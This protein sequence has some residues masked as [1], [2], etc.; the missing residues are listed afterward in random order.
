GTEPWRHMT[1]SIAKWVC[2]E[3]GFIACLG[4]VVVALSAAGSISGERDRD[5][6][7]GLR[8]TPLDHVQILTA[9]RLG[10]IFSAR[11]LVLW[12]CLIWAI[13][14]FHGG[15][16]PW[17]LPVLLLAWLVYAACAAALGLYLS[18]QCRTTM[19]ATMGTLGLL[20]GLAFCP[21]LLG[22]LIDA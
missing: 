15:L 5:T 9:K 21:L 18:I 19:R 1:D 3:G 16:S 4:L 17:R 12:L 10:S 2:I 22:S 11:W 13:G 8:S 7:D 20:A 14:S 6:W